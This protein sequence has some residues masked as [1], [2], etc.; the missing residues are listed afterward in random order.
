[1]DLD[2]K[3]DVPLAPLTTLETGGVARHFLQADDDEL[4]AAAVAWAKERDLAVYIIGGGS[5]IL[6]SDAG[7]DGLVIRM[8][9]RGLAIGSEEDQ[10]DK[11]TVCVS[12]GEEWD[13]FVDTMVAA[14]LAGVECL[15]GIPGSVGAAPIQ[16]IGAYGQEAADTITQVVAL[17]LATLS[18]TTLDPAQCAFGYRDSLFR[19][20]SGTYAILQVS[21]RLT[22]G[23]PP[24]LAYPEL[25]KEVEHADP[26]LVRVR[27]A[28]LR[29]RRRK[30]MVLDPADENRRSVGSFFTNPVLS[31]DEV[32]RVVARA[33]R[34]GVS[35]PGGMPRYST[36]TGETKL[37]A[38]WLIENAGFARGTR[39]G[40]VGI[41]ARH[42][43]ALV[44]L[45][46]ASTAEVLGF[47]STVRSRVLAVF[48]VALEAEAVCLGCDVPWKSR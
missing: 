29:V 12:A 30:S 14:D 7:L 5:N 36:D 35:D 9:T 45:G 18:R 31:S 25:A 26:S 1:M 13:T 34:A 48:G 32:D 11:V 47:A 4:V 6:V 19:R 21:F 8:H 20:R 37:S 39:R 24:S 28:V 15:S 10:G 22:R 2:I 27:E 41:S 46:G 23:G 42:T 44:N 17:E 38:A 43:L 40:R 3:R 33:A 16:N